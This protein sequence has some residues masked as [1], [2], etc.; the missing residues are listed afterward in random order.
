MSG[1]G[2]AGHVW[3]DGRLLPADGAHLSVFDRG[4]Q[5][6]D[7]VFETLRVRGGQ[8][9]ELAEHTDRLRRSAAGLE[10]RLPED[11]AARLA[12]G[13]AVLL[14]AQG[15]D[16]P[17][18][19]ASVRVTVSRGPFRGRGLLPPG[20]VVQPTIAIQAWPVVPPPA[21]HLERGRI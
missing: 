21:D 1:A 12:T 16:G 9:T 15:F 6:G 19:D 14:E 2:P 17:G 3:I 10:I 7:G 4:F 13:I 5:L 20:E 11:I 8:P 18:G